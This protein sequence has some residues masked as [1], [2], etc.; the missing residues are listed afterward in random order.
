[1]NKKSPCGVE[2]ETHCVENNKIITIG[3]EFGSGGRELGRKIAEMLNAAYYDREIITEIAKRTALSEDYVQRIMEHRPIAAFPIHIGRSFSFYPLINP[4]WDQGQA[5]YKE[6]H[7][8]IQEMAQKSDCVIVGRCADYILRDKKPLRIFVYSDMESKIT[9]CR[10]NRAETADN[11]PSGVEDDKPSG[12]EDDNNNMS[13]KELK[14]HII[15]INK[16]RA[17]YYE[18]YTG[19]DWGDKNN[20]DVCVNTTRISIDK[21]ALAIIN[22][23]N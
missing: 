21:A 17:K 16:N 10:A 8:I 1:M 2:L 14:Q 9:R 23:L 18:F 22:L 15:D 4:V 11:K 20:Y 5:I 6:Q 3:R 19:Q 13:D 12:V 7:S